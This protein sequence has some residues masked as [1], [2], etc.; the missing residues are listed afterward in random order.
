[1]RLYRSNLVISIFLLPEKVLVPVWFKMLGTVI[2]CKGY[3]LGLGEII[4][5]DLNFTIKTCT[6][7]IG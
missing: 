1:M 7:G 3:Q 6:V 2:L 4:R 5:A